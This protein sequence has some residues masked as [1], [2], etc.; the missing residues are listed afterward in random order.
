MRALGL[1]PLP[2]DP[3]GLLPSGWPGP[4]SVG[5]GVLQRLGADFRLLGPVLM[6]QGQDGPQGLSDSRCSEGLAPLNWPW[7]GTMDSSPRDVIVD[8]GLC[9]ELTPSSSSASDRQAALAPSTGNANS[10]WGLLGSLGSPPCGS[11]ACPRGGLVASS[12]VSRPQQAAQP[13][14]PHL[15]PLLP[16]LPLRSRG[17]A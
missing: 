3:L 6:S 14:L 7:W 16:L 13:A 15:V 9:L 4:S 8:S 17:Q 1:T 10:W 11:C 12:S 5:A 2:G